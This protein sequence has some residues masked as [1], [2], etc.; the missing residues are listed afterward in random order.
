MSCPKDASKAENCRPMNGCQ[1]VLIDNIKQPNGILGK[2]KYECTRNLN[3][4]GPHHAHNE[5]KHCLKIW[6]D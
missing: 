3:H 2:K 4:T 6:E 5:K 1:A